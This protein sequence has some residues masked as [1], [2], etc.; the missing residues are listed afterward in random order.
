MEI[1]V[2]SKK[3]VFQQKFQKKL[4]SFNRNSQ[5]RSVMEKMI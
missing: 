4:Y 2:H 5:L 1:V 3:S